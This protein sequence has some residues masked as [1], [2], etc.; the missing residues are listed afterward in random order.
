M[1]EDINLMSQIFFKRAHATDFV[2]RPCEPVKF[3]SSYEAKHHTF[4]QID[5]VLVLLHQFLILN[6]YHT[7]FLVLILANIGVKFPVYQ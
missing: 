5:V 2:C 1:T 4:L 6:V 7:L 3:V